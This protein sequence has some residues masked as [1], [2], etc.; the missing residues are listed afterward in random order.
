MK[1][2]QAQ[3]DVKGTKRIREYVTAD[4]FKEIESMEMLAR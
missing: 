2:L 3:Y 4:E 1:E